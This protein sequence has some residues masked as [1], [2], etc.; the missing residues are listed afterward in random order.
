MVH[1]QYFS[2]SLLCLPMVGGI[3]KLPGAFF[4][5]ASFMLWVWQKYI[6][7]SYKIQSDCDVFA[8]RIASF[9]LENITC[10]LG[11]ALVI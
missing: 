11:S 1:R 5:G 4:I 10:L 2:L 7:L 8:Q 6:L 3:R 9:L